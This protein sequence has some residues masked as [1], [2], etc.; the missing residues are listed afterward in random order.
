M[1][2]VEVDG[3][4]CVGGLLV[5]NHNGRPLEFQCTTPVRPDRTQ[6]ILYGQMLRDRGCWENSSEK[7]CLIACP[8]NL[9]LI[10]ISDPDLL[11]LRNHTQDACGL[12]GPN[13]QPSSALHGM[14]QANKT[15]LTSVDADLRFH[16]GHLSDG[17]FVSKSAASDS[18]PGRPGSSHL[19]GFTKR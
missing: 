4:G 11:E 18:G 3:R 16:D 9:Q 5:T 8:S 1:A 15:T 10:V 17:S 19:N 13:K 2:A 6:E 12:H 14:P 7:R